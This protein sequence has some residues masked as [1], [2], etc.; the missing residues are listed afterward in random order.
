MEINFAKDFK[1][2]VIVDGS[3]DHKESKFILQ[4]T[5]NELYNLVYKQKYFETV[6]I[7]LFLSEF[8][9]SQLMFVLLVAKHFL[10]MTNILYLRSNSHENNK[11]FT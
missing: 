3:L 7:C 8:A 6:F 10:N 11:H 5:I 9:F 2:A 1:I 4:M